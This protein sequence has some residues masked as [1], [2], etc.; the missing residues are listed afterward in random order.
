MNLLIF[1]HIGPTKLAVSCGSAMVDSHTKTANGEDGVVPPK[2][3][4][5]TIPRERNG[6]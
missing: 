4:E 2:W 6:R 3:K 1:Y 5:V